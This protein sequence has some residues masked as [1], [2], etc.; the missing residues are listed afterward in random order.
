MNLFIKDKHKIDSLYARCFIYW[1]GFYFIDIPRTSSSSIRSVIGRKF[2]KVYGKKN[3]VDSR[4]ATPQIFTDHARAKDMSALLGNFIWNRIFTF[5]MVR[6]PWDRT[7]SMYNYRKMICNIPKEW[8][9]RD[10]VLI[11][12]KSFADTPYFKYSFHRNGASEYVLGNDG[13]IIVDFI[14]KYESR[15][16]D[17]RYISSRIKCDDLASTHIQSAGQNN[18]HYSKIYDEETKEI[19]RMLYAKDIELF[20]YEFESE[21]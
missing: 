14:A 9:F 12:E 20:G 17:L 3:V 13:E 7:Y 18:K 21:I 8:S 11:L 15:E 10:Y 19:I 5:T 6:N 1:K 16:D 2:G 4:H